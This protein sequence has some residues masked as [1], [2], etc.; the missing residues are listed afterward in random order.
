MSGLSD[1]S[2]AEKILSE[3]ADWRKGE[4]AESTEGILTINEDKVDESNAFDINCQTASVDNSEEGQANLKSSMN[5]SK[6]NVSDGALLPPN[7]LPEQTDKS[8]PNVDFF[9]PRLIDAGE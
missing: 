2:T 3:E 1:T 7:D 4:N 9:A 5:T 8:N 6:L